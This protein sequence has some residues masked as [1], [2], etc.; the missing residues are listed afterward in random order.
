MSA[1]QVTHGT[2]LKYVDYDPTPQAEAETAQPE[3]IALS[4]GQMAARF[5]V[6]ANRRA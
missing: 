3:R 1:S 2:M 6:S 4:I 5:G